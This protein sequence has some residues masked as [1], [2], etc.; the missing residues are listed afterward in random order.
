MA[1]T[2][3]LRARQIRICR[4]VLLA[5]QSRRSPH[6][7]HDAVPEV[8]LT[9]DVDGIATNYHDAGTGAP[10][11]LIHGSGPCVSAWANWRLT[12]PELSK[13][14]RVVAPNILGFGYTERPDGAVY[15]SQTWLNHLVGFLD[16]LGLDRVCVVGN[17]FGGS[18]AM[19]LATHHPERVERLVLMGSVGVLFPLTPGLD[20]V[21]GYE[22]SVANM[23]GRCWPSWRGLFTQRRD[24]AYCTATRWPTSVGAVKTQLVQSR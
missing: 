15:N 20:A 21:W 8:G 24:S 4:R 7:D 16:T 19:Q 9:I 13:R 6:H 22:P 12:I 11:L 10:V 23:P 3:G 18:L 5:Q 14:Y 1:L 2:T 17:S